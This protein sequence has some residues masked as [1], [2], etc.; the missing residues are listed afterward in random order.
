[1]SESI[2]ITNVINSLK[3]LR[4]QYQQ[5]L[6]NLPQ[7]AAFLQVKQST[8]KAAAALGVTASTGPSIAHDVVS[9]MEVAQNKFKEHLTSV[10]EYR[11]LLAINK[12]IGEL[13]DGLVPVALPQTEVVADKEAS[14]LTATNDTGGVATVHA[15]SEDRPISASEASA[16][17]SERPPEPAPITQAATP[18]GPAP[19]ET[20]PSRVASDERAA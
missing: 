17:V 12:L 1:M 3:T 10:P 18:W 14:S 19:A 11:A 5:Q 15:Q 2:A 16:L 20:E 7:Y 9:A 6:E 4:D 13:S 8:E